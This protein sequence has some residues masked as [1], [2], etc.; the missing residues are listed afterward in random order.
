MHFPLR[1]SLLIVLL[2]LATFSA[3]GRAIE[4][5]TL[6]LDELYEL[7]L[8]TDS[9]LLLTDCDIIPSEDD[10]AFLGIFNEVQYVRC[11]VKLLQCR[12]YD[13]SN[14]ILSL[15]N[16]H[17]NQDLI[18]DNCTG[19]GMELISCS[20]DRIVKFIDTRCRYVTI[21]SC[22]IKAPLVFNDCEITECTVEDVVFAYSHPVKN[23][24][25]LYFQYNNE[26]KRLTFRN[27]EFFNQYPYTFYDGTLY[28]KT[29]KVYFNNFT[30]DKFELTNCKFYN[31]P[32][33]VNLSIN[34]SLTFEDNLFAQKV[35]MLG[36]SFPDNN[37][38]IR[39][40]DLEDKICLNYNA[41]DSTYILLDFKTTGD[42]GEKFSA[43]YKHDPY[44]SDVNDVLGVYSKLLTIFD[45]N[46]DLE[47]YN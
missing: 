28:H 23:L 45:N 25:S 27:C 36:V 10:E 32:V 15:K 22:N 17:F 5:K 31:I 38:R 11:S 6:Q 19:Y 26:F 42:F 2:S 37:S 40:K 35:L 14:F 13:N 8:N 12:I 41:T 43:Y 16:L 47:S 29:E 4:K 9:T 20:F 46:S 21:E 39:Y 34:S 44:I 33:F 18:I 30:A 1:N 3:F 7:M 24:F